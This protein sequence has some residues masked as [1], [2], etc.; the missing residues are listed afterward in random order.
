MTFFKNNNKN[1]SYHPFIEFLIITISLIVIL[2]PL[3]IFSREIFADE[4]I[5]SLG[6]IS[7]VFG[8]I[9]FLS[10]KAKLG[11]FGEM[12]LR[13]IVKNH[14]GKKKIVIYVQTGLF[15][16]IGIFT[17]FSINAGNTDYQMLKEQILEEFQ[18]QGMVIDSGWDYDS[19][20]QISSQITPEEQIES[21]ASLPF[22]I[23]ENFEIF[24]VVLSVT[25]QLMG[26]WVMY[27]WQ[28]MVVEITEIT[29]F[30]TIS[31]MYLKK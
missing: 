15:L 7:I 22:L 28:V 14:K 20:E 25:D 6:M 24:S 19:I 26:G 3:R 5:G 16:S 27:F 13:Q 1:T 9:L 18:N 8:A 23:I 29:I 12:F 2:V 10:K 31:K 30:I 21:I 17:I 4:W 11:K